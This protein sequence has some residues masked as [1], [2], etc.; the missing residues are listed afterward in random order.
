MGN[1]V[2]ANSDTPG[3]KDA[4]YL[5]SDTIMTVAIFFQN[6]ALP[7]PL[8]LPIH[9]YPYSFTLPLTLPLP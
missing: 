3:I 9:P 1:I 8:P 7:L 5:P 2:I 4:W 6:L